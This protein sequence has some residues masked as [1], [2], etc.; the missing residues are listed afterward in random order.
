MYN[1]VNDE[2]ATTISIK[3]I[4]NGNE[5]E[6]SWVDFY[7]NYC[8]LQKV[9]KGRYSVTKILYMSGGYQSWIEFE[10]P[11]IT[12]SVNGNSIQ[13]FGSVKIDEEKM[14]FAEEEDQQHNLDQL[15]NI[16]NKQ[17]K[18]KGWGFD[19]E[20]CYTPLT[21]DLRKNN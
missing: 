20:S 19:Q 7:K 4:E 5:F 9:P 2:Y 10:N 6:S 16:L 14:I 11:V 15:D 18:S 8:V 13:Y 1:S 21:V 12:I 3:D 17:F